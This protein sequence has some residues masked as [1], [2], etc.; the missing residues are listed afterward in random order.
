M[1][2]SSFS[3]A[4][5]VVTSNGGAAT[6]SV[7][8]AGSTAFGGAL[9]DGSGG[10]VLSLSFSG[11]KLTLTGNN[12][13]SG[14]NSFSGTVRSVSIVVRA[15]W[16]PARSPSPT[17]RCWSLTA[18]ITAWSLPTA[19]AAT[20]PSTAPASG[21]AQLAGVNTYNG[22]TI[23]STGTLQL[24]SLTALPGGP[25][26]VSGGVFDLAGFGVT[27]S[28][29]SGASTSAVV[30]TNNGAATL[31]VDQA[32]LDGL[33]RCVAERQRRRPA[34]AELQR[35]PARPYRHKHLH[36]P[37]HDFGRHVANRKR[38]GRRDQRQSLCV[39]HN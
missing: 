30:T 27:V 1:T 19:S 21:L 10:G 16:V 33:R 3:G 20:A 23:V 2:V 34:F 28:S 35:R 7:N 29:F 17:T 31:T 18:A 38:R 22:T 39:G 6:L 12:T 9:Q 11:T 37:D 14:T 4:S 15:I 25:L 32:G 8:Q 24:G 5:G 26:A 36:R 13:N